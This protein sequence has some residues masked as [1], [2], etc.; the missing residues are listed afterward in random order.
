MSKLI[1]IAKDFGRHPGGRYRTD[2]DASGE[3]FREDHL[4]PALQSNDSIVIEL[5]GTRGYGS[6]FLE[7][8]FGG[9]VRKGISVE[10]MLSKIEFKSSD[11]S[12]PYEIK[13]YINDARMK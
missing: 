4:I 1:N 12:I 11:S 9:A 10:D 13:Q 5:D 2:G 7:E 6:S 3:A 8:C